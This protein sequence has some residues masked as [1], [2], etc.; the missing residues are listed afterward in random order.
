MSVKISKLVEKI[1]SDTEKM[2][3]M[4]I[5]IPEIREIVITERRERKIKEI[6]S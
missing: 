1:K 5:D 6:N 3:Y 4:F 2:K